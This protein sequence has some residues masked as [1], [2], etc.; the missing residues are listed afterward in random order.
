MRQQTFPRFIVF[1]SLEEVCL[2]KFLPFLIEKVISTRATPKTEK[3][4]R[5][6]NLL[7]EVDSQGQ[8]E[9]ILKMKTFY[10]MKCRANPYEKLNTFKGVIRSKE[11]ALATEKEIA[12]ALGKQGVTNIRISIRKGK[13]RILTFNQ[14]HTR[15]E[16]K[17]SYCLERVEQYILAP[18]KCFKCQKYGHH[19]EACRGRQTCTKCSEKDPDH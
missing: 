10:T 1:E 6:R 2:T 12:S 17:I 16:V 4:T 3:K 9:S 19:R 11:L 14:P 7:V 15:K 18:L 5:N 8:A 13:E